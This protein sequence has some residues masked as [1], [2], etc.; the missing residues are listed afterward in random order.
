MKKIAAS[1]TRQKEEL[2]DFS[3]FIRNTGGDPSFTFEWGYPKE[4]HGEKLPK[5][6]RGKRRLISRPNPAMRALHISFGKFLYE[7]MDALQGPDRSML[8]LKSSTGCVPG[9]NHYMN[10]LQHSQGKYFYITDF[11]HAYPSVDLRRL[12]LLLLFI[13]RREKYSDYSFLM[14]AGNELAHFAL[15]EDPNFQQALGFVR[16]A[17]GGLHGEGLAVGGILSPFLLNL[18]CEVFLDSRL[19]YYCEKKKVHGSPE[20]FITYTRYVDDLV[21][22]RG[23]VF[24]STTRKEIE[25]FIHE[26]GFTV[27][28]RKT[29]ILNVDQGTVFVT[30][31]GMRVAAEQEQSSLVI[32]FPQSKRRRL[33]G[34]IKSYLATPFQNDSPEVVR[35]LAAEF[36][37]YYKLVD[38]PTKTD[39]K[40]FV[41]CKAF[42]QASEKYRKDY[43]KK[44]KKR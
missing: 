33:H 25:R 4:K 31:V 43:K 36:L 3:S 20:T 26:A 16:F 42:E 14:F 23:I 7:R 40:T 19:R 13:L 32:V 41:L 1:V 21:F 5:K 35:G 29:R 38:N 30:K 24:S 39:E 44:S 28:R 22:S 37:Y 12:T 17:F 8:K 18:Y 9:S 34:I 11:S 27:N 10:A 2:I 6:L 15:E